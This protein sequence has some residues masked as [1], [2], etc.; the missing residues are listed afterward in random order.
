MEQRNRIFTPQRMKQLILATSCAMA[1]A[2]LAA[3]AQNSDSLA[4]YQW[5]LH[6]TGQK[7]QA[8]TL[9]VSGV[10]LKVDSA[11][12]A[13]IHGKGVTIAI[14]DDGLQIAHPDLAANIA[15]VAGKNFANQSNDPTPSNLNADNHGTMVG[16]IA[17]AVGNNNVGVRGVAPAATLK[18]FNVLSQTAQGSQTSNIEYSWWSGAEVQDVDVFNNSWGTGPSNGSLPFTF[19]QNEVNSFERAMKSTR[20]GRGGIYVKSAGNNFNNAWNEGDKRDYCTQDTIT[21]GN[22]CIPATRDPR[23]NLQTVITVG[24]VRADGIRSSYSSVGSSLWISAFGGESGWEKSYRSGQAKEYYDPA[25]LTTD[26][27][28]CSEGGNQN[29]LIRNSLDGSNSII[30]KTCN[31]TAKM[32]GT[33]ASAPM[34]SGVAALMLEAN[35]TL[36]YREVKYILATTAVQ[37]DKTHNGWVKNK[38]GHNYS[39]WYGFGL[40]NAAAA[41]DAA[42]KFKTPFPA[43]VDTGWSANANSVAIGGTTK[44]AVI[45]I[46]FTS[47]PSKI[48]TVQIGFEVSHTNTRRIQFVLISPAG[49]RSVVQPAYTAIGSGK[50][51]LFGNT[52]QANFSAW[53]FVASNAFLDEDG[54][55]KWKLEVSDLGL[56]ASAQPL[57]NLT[58]FN[59]RV[60]GH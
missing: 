58:S 40:V 48:E 21:K 37:T 11:Y 46:D 43:L 6:N 10:D 29:S 42:D 22:G 36:S 47:A 59:I 54:K 44:P 23:N 32:N 9:P 13:G 2:P 5:H 34:I 38:A 18:G 15:K 28:G 26:A 52:T 27:I 12:K 31:Y 19:S 60:L 3:N 25:I 45:S 57:G 20:G 50:H 30:D 49:T 14:V 35:P 56:G 8:D 24:A 17:G 55:G 1:L 51:W 41:I 39:N 7:V 33:S 16:G 53:N 4:R